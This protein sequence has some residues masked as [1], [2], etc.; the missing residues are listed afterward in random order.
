MS[1]DIQAAWEARLPPDDLYRDLL[2]SFTDNV[3]PS[4]AKGRTYQWARWV[5]FSNEEG[6]RSLPADPLHVAI[7]LLFLLHSASNSGHSQAPVVESAQAIRFAHVQAGFPA[8]TDQFLPEHVVGLARHRLSRP[9]RKSRIMTVAI[10]RSLAEKLDLSDVG[11]L[12]LF[13][14]LLVGFSGFLRWDDLMHAD[15]EYYIFFDKCVYIFIVSSKTDQVRHGHWLVLAAV[16]GD[17]CPVASLRRLIVKAG[18]VRGKLL[19]RV[20]RTS[21]GTRLSDHPLS[22]T[23]FLE[24][25]RKALQI[26]GMDEMEAH[27]FGTR[28]LRMGGDPRPQTAVSPTACSRSTGA[29]SPNASRMGTWPGPCRSS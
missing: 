27:E 17:L 25:L 19:R 20:V 4:T 7:F 16:G 14:S 26:A 9:P 29:G 18:L 1:D 3:A 11:W 21:S 8:P 22:Y 12:M 23:R 6:W 5:E 15:V 28:C 24:L 2:A 10:L 13:T